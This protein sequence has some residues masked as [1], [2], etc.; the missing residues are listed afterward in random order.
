MIRFPGPATGRRVDRLAATVTALATL[1][2]ALTVT[3]AAPASPAPP[4]AT[5]RP[6]VSPDCQAPWRSPVAADIVDFFRPPSNPYGPGNL[7]LEYRT[8]PGDIVTAV[9]DGTISFAGSVGGSR[10]VVVEH[11]SGLKS[12][13]GYLL[14]GAGNSVGGDDIAVTVGE[15]VIGGQRIARADRGFHLTARRGSRYLDPLPLLNLQCV[16]VRLVSIPT[17]IELIELL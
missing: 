11:P 9:A 3:G 10:F 14:A 7:G 13:Y 17:G 15:S 2:M 8:E 6:A 4:S 1:V 16:E 12:T 5:E